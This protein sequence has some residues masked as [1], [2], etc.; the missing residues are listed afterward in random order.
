MNHANTVCARNL[1]LSLAMAVALTAC[2]ELP[3]R[4]KA[5]TPTRVV[6]SP[7]SPPSAIS[8]SR[9]DQDGL[10]S[11]AEIPPDIAAMPDA[12]PRYEPRSTFGNPDSYEVY[13]ERYIVLN[14]FANFKERGIASWY[15]KKF[16][17]KNTSSGE[18]YDMFLMTAAHKT[19]PIPC[20]VRVTNLSNQR[21]AIVRVNDRG[22]FH[23]DRIIDLSYVAALK[24]GVIGEG[25]APVEIEALTPPGPGSPSPMLTAQAA[26]PAP[27]P[28]T[29][30]MTALP[31]KPATITMPPPAPTTAAV[32]I[33]NP[34][35]VAAIASGSTSVPAAMIP[36]Y[37][38]AD[39]HWLQAGAFLDAVNATT[40]RDQL[41]GMGI[42]NVQLKV[43]PRGGVALHRVL[44]GPFVD[45]QSRDAVRSRLA[46]VQLPSM[47]VS[48]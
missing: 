23:S 9:P 29:Q 30:S 2:E 34:A 43:Q 48:D 10:P 4:P 11:A 40:L 26:A 17:G 35:T 27:A 44:I 15:G 45:A 19:L 7:T 42:G 28:V 18:P 21:S 25:S 1:L 36:N 8:P 22:P 31:P 32:P 3:A 13:G 14:D 41:N 37:F 16:H 47:P 12:V 38:S 39:A 6:R 46:S 24:L 20:Y 5:R 33:T